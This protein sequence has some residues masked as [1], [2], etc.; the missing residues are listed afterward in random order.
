MTR[1]NAATAKMIA[2]ITGTVI[3]VTAVMMIMRLS[4]M[5]NYSWWWIT[6]PMWF[7]ILGFICLLFVGASAQYIDKFVKEG[8]D[9]ERL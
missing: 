7:F 2:L 6:A 1:D 9:D 8:K 4:G 5:V 3:F